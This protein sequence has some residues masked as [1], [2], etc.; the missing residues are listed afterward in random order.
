M[1]LN[2]SG[3]IAL[4]GT[5]VGQSIEIENGGNGTTQISL[6]DAAVRRLASVPSGAI[7]MPTNFWGKAYYVPKGFTTPSLVNGNTL[8]Y[9]FNAITAKSTNT[10]CMVGVGSSISTDGGVTWTSPS[11]V[12]SSTTLNCLTTNSSGT[13][14]G[15]GY[16]G[17]FIPIAATST[18]GT[19]WTLS[20]PFPGS[21]SQTFM[22]NV[23]YL[24]SG[25]YLT[26][27][28]V[29]SNSLA[30]FSTSTDGTTWT[31]PAAIGNSTTSAPLKNHRGTLIRTSGGTIVALGFDGTTL[32][33]IISTSTNGTTWSN[34]S[35]IT[36]TMFEPIAVAGTSSDFY[37]AVG[38]MTGYVCGYSISSN[39]TTWTNP[40]ALPSN[41]PC[42]VKSITCN[43]DGVFVAVGNYTGASPGYG[44]YSVSTDGTTWSNWA[45]FNGN[46]NNGS[47]TGIVSGASKKFIIVGDGSGGA[48]GT[49]VPY[50]SISTP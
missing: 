34:W 17:S 29:N 26:T 50:Y 22:L 39:G 1:T 21:T 40:V 43:S 35:N 3:P 18:N 23:M 48:I 20:S 38:L 49:S 36:T 13:F 42:T 16:N 28:Y 33:G 47:P 10:Y 37:V 45:T 32:N 12:G 41:V 46:T 30:V 31:T 9:Q 6:N 15:V 5:T 14:I 19:S 11:I 27:G 24:P 2:A 44:L 4:A 25:T 8:G 7:S